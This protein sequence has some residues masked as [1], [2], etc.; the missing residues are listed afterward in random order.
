VRA[1]FDVLRRA[2]ESF[3]A[4]RDAARLASQALDLAN[5]A[6]TAGATTDIEVIDAERAARDAETQAEIA[7]DAARQARL[8]LLGATNRFP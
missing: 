6:Y 5:L 3:R 7:A 8:N 2:D 4:S 1:A